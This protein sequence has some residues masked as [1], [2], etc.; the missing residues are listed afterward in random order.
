MCKAS[1]FQSI[2]QDNAVL[3]NALFN[4]A[5]I[6]NITIL[7]KYLEKGHTQMEADPSAPKLNAELEAGTF[8]AQLIVLQQSKMLEKKPCPYSVKY[9]DHTFFHKIMKL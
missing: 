6:K 7:Q 1:D 2:I 4:L 3:G 8:I 5:K 9:L